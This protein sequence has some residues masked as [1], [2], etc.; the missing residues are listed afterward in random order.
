MNWN[1]EG[2]KIEA[3]Y[4]DVPVCGVITHSRVAYGGGV[5]HHLVLDA[6]YSNCNGRVTRPAGDVVIVDH[7]TV[8]RVMEA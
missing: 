2:L 5:K 7:R 8:S 3:E 1:L 6:D 4:L